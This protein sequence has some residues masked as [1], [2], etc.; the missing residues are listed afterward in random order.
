M[1]LEIELD[2]NKI[3]YVA[4]NKQIAEKIAELNIK[5]A[6]ELQIETRINDA[7][8]REIS[9]L[10]DSG[11]NN[12]IA[13]RHRW[14]GPITQAGKNLIDDVSRTEIET[15]AKNM[16]DEFFT[17][18]R[19]NELREIMMQMIPNV[20]AHVM[21][22][23]LEGSLFTNDY[24]YRDTMLSMMRSEIESRINNMSRHF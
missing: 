14:N 9:E 7:I 22:S 19:V 17:E 3:D 10:I 23:R 24:N 20:F 21:F 18:D 2:L 15:R 4:I 12:Y 13:N 5:E 11:F 6:H 8:K 1:K 16:M